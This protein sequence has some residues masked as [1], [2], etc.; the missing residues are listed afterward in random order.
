[1]LIIF[2]SFNPLFVKLKKNVHGKHLKSPKKIAPQQLA[3]NL[4]FIQ[5]KANFEILKF[6]CKQYISARGSGEYT[7]QTLNFIRQ[8]SCWDLLFTAEF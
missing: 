2:I 1:M 6:S 7:Q 3:L 4:G 8:S 5:E